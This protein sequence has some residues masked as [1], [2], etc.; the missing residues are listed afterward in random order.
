MI[1]N[2]ER[3]SRQVFFSGIGEVG[4]SCIS[5]STILIV[6]CGALGSNMANLLARAGV[7]TVKIVDRDFVELSNLQRQVLFDEMDAEKRLPKAAATAEK[8]KQIN[9]DI[10][11]EAFIHDVN[12]RNIETMLAGVDLVLDATDNMETRYLVNDACV[13]H[14]IP[15]IYG[16]VIG[17]TGM[18]MDIIPGKSACLRCLSDAPPAP[19]SMPTCETEGVLGGTP[20]VIASIQA[21]EALKIMVG[22]HPTGGNLIHIDLW[23][24]EF[25]R[26]QVNQRPDCPACVGKR[27]DFLEGEYASEA[28]SLC[29]RNAVQITA[30]REDQ[31]DLKQLKAR[32]LS[33]GEVA[34]NDFF[35]TFKV[36]QYE[37]II[38][39]EARAI[40]KGTSDETV[41]RSLFAKYV[42]N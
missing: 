1:Q 9:G 41:A 17:A 20:A 19:G 24:N 36:D 34:D 22:H 32:L 25:N 5:K 26:F 18:T 37:L 39:P 27:F 13:K 11:V 40:I 6:G 2:F 15:W 35:L 29:G 42:G 8:L 16:G 38:F 12:P 4:Q 31:L 7:G 21:T 30:S 33:L 23:E 10:R 3:Y 14:Q 28:F